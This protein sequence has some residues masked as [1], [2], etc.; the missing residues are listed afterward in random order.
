MQMRQSD[1]AVPEKQWS[2]C[3]GRRG[4]RDKGGRAHS[5]P[6]VL[7]YCYC[8]GVTM[9]EERVWVIRRPLLL[10]FS[11]PPTS[12]NEAGLRRTWLIHSQPSLK[13]TFVIQMKSCYLRDHLSSYYSGLTYFT[14]LAAWTP[15]IKILQSLSMCRRHMC[16]NTHT[17]PI[18]KFVVLSCTAEWVEDELCVTARG[19]CLMLPGATHAGSVFIQST[20]TYFG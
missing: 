5:R 6:E 19:C 17:V 7:C 18:P 11:L 13:P 14:V 8:S 1:N 15:F 9:R 4:D 10:C 20:I 12:D 16:T 2:K 3:R